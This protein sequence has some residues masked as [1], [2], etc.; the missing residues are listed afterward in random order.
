MGDSADGEGAGPAHR[1]SVHIE[2]GNDLG[3]HR[4]RI[5]G[6]DIV[7]GTTGDAPRTG[8]TFGIVL[9]GRVHPVPPAA[10]IAVLT[11]LAVLPAV[12]AVLALR[13]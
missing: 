12:L 1:S 11:A 9:R 4:A 5:A 6:R 8:V 13:A 7:G 2:V 10:A 3:M